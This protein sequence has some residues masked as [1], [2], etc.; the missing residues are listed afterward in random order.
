[1]SKQNVTEN[2]GKRITDSF[3]LLHRIGRPIGMSCFTLPSDDETQLIK[4]T[5]LDIVLF[6]WMFCTNIYLTYHNYQFWDKVS[7]IYKRD[8]IFNT[9]IKVISTGALL[10]TLTGGI[11]VLVMRERIWYI[12]VTLEDI[13]EKVVVLTCF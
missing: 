10:F 12:L 3:K 7:T 5:T 4:I 9:G 2:R 1:M 11:V 6:I 8:T 13:S